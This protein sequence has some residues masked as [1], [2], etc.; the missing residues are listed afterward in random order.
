MQEFSLY[1]ITK[2]MA[3]SSENGD[4]G[5]SSQKSVL[6]YPLLPLATAPPP[7]VAAFCVLLSQFPDRM[8]LDP[9]GGFVLVSEAPA[10]KTGRGKEEEK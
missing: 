5:F 6:L 2:A 9:Q 1:H 3:L 8:G 10:P 4:G 7:R